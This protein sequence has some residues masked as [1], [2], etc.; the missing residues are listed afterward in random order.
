[1][2]D[3]EL[4]DGW[5]GGD[6]AVGQALLKR[7]LRPL[8]RF[9]ANK[10][11]EQCDDLIQTTMMSVLRAKDQFRAD[12]SFRTY[13]FVVARNVLHRSLRTQRRDR[14]VFDP[15]TTSV[16]EVTSSPSTMA[17]RSQEQRILLDALRRIPV[18]LQITLELHYWEDLTTAELALILD[19][20]QGTVK[21]RL[22]R[23]REQL[24][25]QIEALTAD[26]DQR[27]RTTDHIERW[28]AEIRAE[29][30]VA[31]PHGDREPS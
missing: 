29:A 8:Y 1:M 19:I 16:W 26:P 10:A 20:P 25:A 3:E 28:A 18:D 6:P 11:G 7:H 17:A 2:T 4:L 22:R 27:A 21:S 12:S 31:K 24:V 5:R 15:E 30:G 13:L 23:A 9:F 14:L